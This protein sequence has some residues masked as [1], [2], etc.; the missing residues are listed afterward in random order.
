MVRRKG[1]A[2]VKKGEVWHSEMAGGNRWGQ[3]GPTEENAL[4]E[5]QCGLG[6]EDSKAKTGKWWQYGK[7][8]SKTKE[9]WHRSRD[10]ACGPRRWKGRQGRVREVHGD[11]GK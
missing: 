10:M 1:D 3:Q 6:K 8:R 4:E 9:M 11:E 7:Q 2:G 5:E